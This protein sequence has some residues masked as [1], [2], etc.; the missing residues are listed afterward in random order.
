MAESTLTKRALAS[1]LKELMAEVPFEK[2]TVAQICEKCDMNR[3]SFYYHFRDKYDLVDWIFDM[4]FLSV[5]SQDVNDDHM[6]FL[7]AFC[8]LFY[9]NR[10]F[11]RKALEI[12]GQ[13]SFSDHFKECLIPI[14]QQRHSFLYGESK[15]NS[16]ALSVLADVCVCVLER[17]LLEKD[18]M[19]PEQLMPLLE[20]LLTASALS[21]Y[22]GLDQTT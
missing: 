19:T 17:W 22:K 10:A 2:I 20:S 8:K 21:L 7:N 3:K 4:D 11:Y 14:V 9:E 18:C 16:F 13:N 12:K 6:A 1:A 15:P 5:L